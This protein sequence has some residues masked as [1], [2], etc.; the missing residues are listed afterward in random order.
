MR[1][2]RILFAV[3]ILMVA[4]GAGSLWPRLSA[5]AQS[6]TQE[7][8]RLKEFGSSVKRLKW[9]PVKQAAVEARS[10]DEQQQ[11]ATSEDVIRI[12]TQLVV[13][14]VLILDKKGRA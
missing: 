10:A 9:D 1:Y 4:A 8:P 14:D 3:L 11:A 6:P 7:K 2:E 13:C 12:D 5:L